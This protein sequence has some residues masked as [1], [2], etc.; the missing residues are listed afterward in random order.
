M[1]LWQWLLQFSW[2]LKHLHFKLVLQGRTITF[3]RL[4]PVNV[5][6]L[7]QL[8]RAQSEVSS[9]VLIRQDIV[10]CGNG[11]EVIFVLVDDDT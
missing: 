9:Y 10:S 5:N 11:V 2:A 6:V 8:L 7:Q 1:L 4:I 3:D